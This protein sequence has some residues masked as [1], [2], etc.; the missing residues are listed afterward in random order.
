MTEAERLA[1]DPRVSRLLPPGDEILWVGRPDPDV[2][3]ARADAWLVPL[4]T[5][6][7]LVGVTV[8][9]AKAPQLLLLVL[10]VMGYLVVGRFVVKQRR[11]RR[12]TYA[13][14]RSCALAITPG[15]VRRYA[16]DG[17]P[18]RVVFDRGRVHVTVLFRRPRPTSMWIRTS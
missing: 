17:T 16:L 1:A 2:L 12:T 18:R 4:T 11:K 5:V 15:E 9:L 3:F 6:G 14:T 10:P 13:V 8:S 7:F